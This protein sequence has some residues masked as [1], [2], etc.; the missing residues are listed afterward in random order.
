MVYTI[1]ETV[2]DIVFSRMNP[3]AAKVGGS[4]LNSAV[5]CSQLGARVSFVSE[6]GTDTVG[7]HCLN[8]L[9]QHA[10]ST[11]YVTRY[12]SHP[13]SLALAFL[14]AN[15][16][17]SYNF[18]KQLPAEFICKPIP[19]VSEDI[20]LFSSSFAMNARSRNSLVTILQKAIG[21]NALRMYD[22]NMRKPINQ[23]SLEMN[24]IHENISYA[25]I[26]RASYED[27]LLLFNHTRFDEIF[28]FLYSKGVQVAVFTKSN[29]AV[30]IFTSYMHKQYAVPCINPISTIGAGDTF[31]AAILYALYVKKV[32]GETLPYVSVDFWDIVI[33]FAIAC[34]SRVCMSYDNY[35]DA[36]EAEQLQQ[37]YNVGL[38]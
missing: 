26:V 36:A 21:V 27:C 9:E 15:S 20:V 2:F 18:Y 19:L 34:S 8:F 22:P 24:Y 1:G 37:L 6:I 12:D 23:N 3:I 13:T 4:A 32:S 31:N 25:H 16:N 5:T 11:N 28:E 38:L 7:S 29:Q 14:D 17:A 30:E 33:P 35:L 10:I